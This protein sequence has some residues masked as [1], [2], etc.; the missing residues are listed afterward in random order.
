MARGNFDRRHGKCIK[1]YPE[2]FPNGTGD[3]AAVLNNFSSLHDILVIPFSG[4]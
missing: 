1:K 4:H 3:N 2:V